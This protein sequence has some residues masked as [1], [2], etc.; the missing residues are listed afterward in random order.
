M[1]HALLAPLR[2]LVGGLGAQWLRGLANDVFCQVGLV[3][4]IGLAIVGLGYLGAVHAAGMAA[5]ACQWGYDL[6][7]Y[8]VAYFSLASAEALFDWRGVGRMLLNVLAIN[9]EGIANNFFLNPPLL[10][11]LVMIFGALLLLADLLA[12][13]IAD[14][15]LSFRKADDGVFLLRQLDLGLLGSPRSHAQ[16]GFE[17]RVGGQVFRKIEVLQ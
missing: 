1:T 13:L 14:A 5:L 2:R 6:N 9:E 7:L 11:L 4:L 8:T 16:Q 3:M 17:L 10:A 15:Q 12:S